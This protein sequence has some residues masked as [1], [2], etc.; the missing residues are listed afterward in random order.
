MKLR[1]KLYINI[2]DDLTAAPQYEELDMFDFESIELTS[3]IQEIRDIGS[4]FT[5]FSQ[6]FSVP[7]SVNN[8]RI[9]THYYNTNLEN[10]F[11]A[12]IKKKGLITINN[13]TFREGYI[14]L[15]EVKL[16]NNRASSYK[17]TFFGELVNL[18]QVLGD[19]ELKDLGNLD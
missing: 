19:D 18:K 6:E 1:T 11:D 3:S 10:Q 7:A 5:D 4:V 13:L 17:L 8:N 2:N 15:S 16:K 14:R 9:F 12:R